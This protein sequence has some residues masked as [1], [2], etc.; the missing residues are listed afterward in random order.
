MLL[1][2][3]LSLKL[4][5][6]VAVVLAF[7]LAIDAFAQ[8]VQ[9]R[10]RAAVGQETKCGK[11]GQGGWEHEE[12]LVDLGEYVFSFRIVGGTKEQQREC[13]LKELEQE[14]G[15]ASRSLNNALRL[16]AAAIEKRVGLDFGDDIFC[17]E[18]CP[19]RNVVDPYCVPEFLNTQLEKNV[20]HDNTG[21]PELGSESSGF[22]FS[23]L[24]CDGPSEVEDI[25][26]K[27][28]KGVVLVR[29]KCKL[30]CGSANF[31]WRCAPCGDKPATAVETSYRGNSYTIGCS[32]NGDSLS[33]FQP[34]TQT[35]LVQGIV[36]KCSKSGTS[37]ECNNAAMQCLTGSTG[38]PNVSASPSASPSGRTSPL[39]SPMGSGSPRQ[40]ASISGL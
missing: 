37:Q 24:K 14:F 27:L 26:C 38:T 29:R 6:G 31:R 2:S 21:S 4:F 19:I 9:E 34:S 16:C 28:H 5:P 8:S 35:A 25:P 33:A 32:G 22:A 40:R 3:R 15:K 20:L 30:Q 12:N 36:D 18:Y 11:E 39:S 7:N 10:P 17:T 23:A 1:F 13:Y